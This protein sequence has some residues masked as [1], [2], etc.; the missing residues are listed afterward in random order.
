MLLAPIAGLLPAPARLPSRRPVGRELHLH[1]AL[2]G[3]VEQRYPRLGIARRD[4]RPRVTEAVAPTRR[5][6]RRWRHQRRD[7]RRTGGGLADVVRPHKPRWG[8][9]MTV[10]WGMVGSLLVD[11]RAARLIKKK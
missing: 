3:G 6:H 1:G 5:H 7:E 4:R 10:G 8:N 2:H 9:R 11:I